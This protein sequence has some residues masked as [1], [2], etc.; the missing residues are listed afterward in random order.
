[1]HGEGVVIVHYARR[2]H[3]QTPCHAAWVC[4]LSFE[5]LMRE[6]LAGFP[7][8]VDLMGTGSRE[9][10]ESMGR[11]RQEWTYHAA[12]NCSIYLLWSEHPFSCTLRAL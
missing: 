5:V 9:T 4:G 2:K 10:P 11:R 7:E 6:C 1:M 3:E 12:L 8:T